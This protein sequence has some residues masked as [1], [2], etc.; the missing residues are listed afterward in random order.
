ML[1][2]ITK[3]V[4]FKR[5]LASTP[6]YTLRRTWVQPAFCKTRIPA[7]AGVGRPYRL[8]PKASVRL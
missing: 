2:G 8:Y 7:V 6:P 1:V 3:E 4:C 5:V